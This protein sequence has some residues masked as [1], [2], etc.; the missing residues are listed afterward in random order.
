M[1]AAQNGH[2]AVGRRRASARTMTP[3]TSQRFAS[4]A[5]RPLLRSLLLAGGTLLTLESVG[6]AQESADFYRGKT[7]TLVVSTSSGGDYDTRAR[8]LARHMTRHVPGAPKFVVQ[9]MPG[10][11]GLRGANWL[12][13]VAAQDGTALAALQQQIPLSQLFKKSGVEF[14]MSKLHFIGNTSAS[15]IVV[16]SWSASPIKSFADVFNKE[17]VVGGTGGGSAS[18]QM[19]LMLNALLGAKFKVVPGYPGGSEIYLAMERG[20][21]AGRVTQSWA[22]WKSQKPDWIAERKIIPLAQGGRKRHADLAQTPLL[23]DFARSAQDR[24]LIQ[25]ML[26]SDEVARPIIAAQGTP[27][28]RVSIL[29]GAFMATMHDP[30]FQADAGKLKLDIEAMSG[31][32]AQAIVSDMM[33]APAVIIERAKTYMGSDG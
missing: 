3:D 10:A 28:D 31:E 29:R 21:I 25:F 16:M 4:S 24:Q 6:F 12:Y 11:G 9:N 33:S 13:N 14:D 5:L 17:F 1:C 27:P 7:I 26:S 2:V 30:D 23:A 20:E 32:E 22:G 19:P 8:L 18:V 15:P